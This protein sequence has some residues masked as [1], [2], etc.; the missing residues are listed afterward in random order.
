MQTLKLGAQT[1]L[2]AYVRAVVVVVVVVDGGL[3]NLLG[4]CSRNWSCDC[5]CGLCFLLTFHCKLL[6]VIK[7]NN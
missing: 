4:W 3:K 7:S 2:N 5:F 1:A 6:F